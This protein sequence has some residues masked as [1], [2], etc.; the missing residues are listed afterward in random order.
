RECAL[1]RFLHG[2]AH[3]P[4]HLEL[5]G[6]TG[7]AELDSKQ[8]DSPVS[9]DCSGIKSSR[10]QWIRRDQISA[11][12]FGNAYKMF[13]PSLPV[14]VTEGGVVILERAHLLELFLYAAPPFDSEANDRFHVVAGDLAVRMD[15]LNQAG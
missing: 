7:D 15:D 11:A 2:T 1:D 10:G 12:L 6:S 13:F 3:S 5:A 8:A 4:S 14:Q 9:G